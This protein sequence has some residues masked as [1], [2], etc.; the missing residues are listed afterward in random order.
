[1]AF[2]DLFKK[3]TGD[4]PYP[5]PGA[6]MMPPPTAQPDIPVSYVI[7][8]QQ[9]GLT[10]NQIIQ[11]LQ[12]QGFQPNQ[13]YDALAQAEAK[14]S[15]EPIQPMDMP[16]MNAE[17]KHPDNEALI[18]QIIHEKWQDLQKDIAKVN[19]WKDVMTS[20]LDRME[21]GMADLR[22]DLEGLHK[23]IVSRVGEYDKTLMDVGT[24]IKAMEKVFQKVLPELTSNVQ[25]LS[26]ITKNVKK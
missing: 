3:K 15:I 4:T 5:Q 17:P 22:A 7:T 14:R 1:M 20:R 18:E 23:A 26:K 13:I 11:S 21:Q 12:R 8:M 25:E 2:T 9:Q 19:E 16:N 10:N 24:E 6:P